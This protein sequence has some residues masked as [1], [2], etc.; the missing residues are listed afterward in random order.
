MKRPIAAKIDV[1]KKRIVYVCPQ[2]VAN[3]SGHE[4]EKIC[5]HC[6][7]ELNWENIS[8]DIPEKFLKEN[9]KDYVVHQKIL[10]E[11]NYD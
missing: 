7:K 8:L 11:I 1:S 5:P 10:N 4:N 3:L 6:K 9:L 2:C